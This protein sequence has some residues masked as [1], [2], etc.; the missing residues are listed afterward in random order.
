MD[1]RHIV[2]G[3]SALALAAP[4]L[5]QVSL[6]KPSDSIVAIVQAEKPCGGNG[7][8]VIVDAR[9]LPDGNTAPF[10]IPAG[11]AFMV[12]GVDF[13]TGNFAGGTASGDRIGF[14]LT[15]LTND[16]IIAE[17]YSINTGAPGSVS[18]GVL[19]PTPMPVT[20]PLCLHRT[21]A[22]VI[23]GTRS[24]VRGFLYRYF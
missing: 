6:L 3:F 19:L 24:W 13:V 1:L 2:F 12:T 14:A 11:Y 4:A 5:G 22:N 8:G 18:G 17:G 9:I 10:V 21:V 16:L 15:T 20:V 7:N 23:G